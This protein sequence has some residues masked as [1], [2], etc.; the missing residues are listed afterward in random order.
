[1]SD[2]LARRRY[3][4]YCITPQEFITLPEGTVLV[5]CN[6]NS[7]YVIGEDVFVKRLYDGYLSYGFESLLELHVALAAARK[8]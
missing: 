3:N 6:T 2:H 1:M 8:Q 7:R 5:G 4:V